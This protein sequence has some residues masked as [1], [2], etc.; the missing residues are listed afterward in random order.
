MDAAN[1]AVTEVL[2]SGCRVK[3]RAQKPEDRAEMLAA[4]GRT[5]ARSLYRRFFTPRRSF[6]EREIAFFL[7]VDFVNHVALVAEIDE[8]VRPV[9]AG[10]GRYIVVRPGTAEIA[11]TVIDQYQGQ[12][13]GAALMRHLATIA[14][15]AG[16]KNLIAEVLPDNIAMLTVFEQSGLPATV[17]REPRLTHVNLRLSER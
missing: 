8:S 7:N 2:R 11:F 15:S 10:G 17:T 6:S 14:K 16:I 13:I 5:G 4:L 1:Y 12:G 9:I 3:I